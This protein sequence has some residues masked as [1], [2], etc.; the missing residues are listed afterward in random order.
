MNTPETLSLPDGRG[1]WMKVTVAR[2]DEGGWQTVI[3]AAD[4]PPPTFVP[5]S[6]PLRQV[7]GDL[8]AVAGGG[9]RPGATGLASRT[10]HTMHAN[11]EQ[12][13]LG[14]HVRRTDKNGW[15]GGSDMRA[16]VKSASTPWRVV[17]FGGA[18]TALLGKDD[19]L[20]DV[21][22]DPVEGPWYAG[23]PLTVVVHATST[24]GDAA[25]LTPTTSYGV[26]SDSDGG[27]Y[28]GPASGALTGPYP[29]VGVTLRPSVVLAPSPT[30]ARGSWVIVGDSILHFQPH[31]YARKAFKARGLASTFNGL[32]GES[33]LGVVNGSF[34]RRLEQELKY[35]DSVL[36]EYGRN[37]YLIPDTGDAKIAKVKQAM[38]DLWK[39]CRAN[40]AARVVQITTTA[41]VASTD[42]WKTLENQTPTN[43]PTERVAVNQWLRDGAPLISGALAPTGTA[44]PSAVRTTVV[45][46]D[47]TIVRGSDAH[48]LGQGGF[49]SDCTSVIES[50]IDSGKVR[51]DQPSAMLTDNVH[52]SV[53]AHNLIAPVLERD[54]RLMGY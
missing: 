52:I 30:V 21:Y 8:C 22:S 5:D 46:L 11:A 45:K 44:D 18:E 23:E 28:D 53:A 12:I 14:W 36:C 26:A 9:W 38:L 42:G 50:A 41:A 40:G 16:W 43:A 49:I 35:A 2:P 48:P 19:A 20:R 27:N 37:D 17:R 10:G 32:G 25:T 4:V 15:T 34:P 39:M 33:A 29:G 24:G 54:L 6:G 31:P 51:V 1:G 13:V 47:G 3:G 7:G